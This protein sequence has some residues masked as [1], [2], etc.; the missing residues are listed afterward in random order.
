MKIPTN[1]LIYRLKD[2]MEWHEFMTE[3]EKAYYFVTDNLLPH[4][5]PPYETKVTAWSGWPAGGFPM[6]TNRIVKFGQ[7]IED[8]PFRLDFIPNHCKEIESGK[9]D[10]KPYKVPPGEYDL[11]L[12]F[13]QNEGHDITIHFNGELV[14]TITTT[15]FTSTTFHYDRGGQGYPENY[16]TNKATDKKKGNYDRDGGKVGVVTIEGDEPVEVTI[17]FSGETTNGRAINLHHWCLKPTKNCY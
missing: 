5:T 15:E 8:I 16:D 17:S 9:Y 1:V 11:C 13:M 2:K 12:G 3:E 7:D 14:R 6:I 10:I 4:G